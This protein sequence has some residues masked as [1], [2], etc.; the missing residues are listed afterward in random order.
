MFGRATITLGIGPHSSSF[1]F[2]QFQLTNSRVGL[3]VIFHVNVNKP[4]APLPFPALIPICTSFGTNDN[5][6]TS[7]YI[8]CCETCSWQVVCVHVNEPVYPLSCY[9][10]D[11]S[12][13]VLSCGKA[14]WWFTR[15]SSRRRAGNSRAT[16]WFFIIR[17]P[18]VWNTKQ[19]VILP[20]LS[21]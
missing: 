18:S 3:L 11:C 10:C 15:P 7:S 19:W 5:F 2:W 17:P 8:F 13:S 9:V 4:V 20:F 12:S 16:F 6:S 21:F 1:Y 14:W